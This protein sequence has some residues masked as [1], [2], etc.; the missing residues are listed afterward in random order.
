MKRVTTGLLIMILTAALFASCSNEPDSIALGKYYLNAESG[1]PYVHVLS[2]TEVELVNFDIDEVLKVYDIEDTEATGNDIGA[3]L[4]ET[5]IYTVAK[6]G[7][8][9]IVYA[10]VTGVSGLRIPY[11]PKTKQLELF[12]EVYVWSDP[13]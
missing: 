5:L 1:S 2:E 12:D 11:N 7:N 6:D 9:L 3:A 13:E 4:Q 10:D 8:M